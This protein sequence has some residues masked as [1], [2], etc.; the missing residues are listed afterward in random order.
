MGLCAD[1]FH[2]Q[3]CVYNSA[4]TKL[5]HDS[6]ELLL[7]NV[8]RDGIGLAYRQ[9]HGLP[10]AERTVPDLLI[11]MDNKAYLCDVTVAD[12]L[13]D[14][15]MACSKQGPGRLA[16]RKAAGRQANISRWL[17]RCG[18]SICRSRWRLWAG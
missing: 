13:A 9:Q 15:N 10:A 18:R 11:Y 3:R 2:G 1:G 6:I 16:D 7:H 14:G 17:R 4:Y 12:T 5:R 8:V